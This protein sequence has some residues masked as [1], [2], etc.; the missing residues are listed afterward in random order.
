MERH[1]FYSVI[2]KPIK[3]C[4]PIYKDS[5]SRRQL[6]M[7]WTLLCTKLNFFHI[8]EHLSTSSALHSFKNC[9]SYYI[10]RSRSTT[11]AAGDHNPTMFLPMIIALISII[12]PSYFSLAATIDNTK[13]RK[14]IHGQLMDIHDGNVI[15]VGD[16]YHW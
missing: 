6:E 1:F 9:S 7:L 10:F 4:L 12:L 16:L 11:A 3:K 8:F 15:K 2:Y 13:P 14:D 5:F